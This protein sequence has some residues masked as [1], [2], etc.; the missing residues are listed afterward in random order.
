MQG[1]YIY[2]RIRSYWNPAEKPEAQAPEETR[3]W[4]K[5]RER[6]WPLPKQVD[7]VQEAS[8]LAVKF[9]LL[10]Q[11]EENAL[12]PQTAYKLCYKKIF[13]HTLI[14]DLTSFALTLKLVWPMQISY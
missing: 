10:S 9:Q 8:V 1:P 12:V 13:M 2:L 3:G 11:H 7:T 4:K 6:A 5:P 14:L